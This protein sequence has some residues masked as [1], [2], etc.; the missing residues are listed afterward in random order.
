MPALDVSLI[1][2]YFNPRPRKE[3]DKM[4][5]TEINELINFNP[6]PRKEGDRRRHKKINKT[7]NFN[8]RPRKEGD[9]LYST[10]LPSLVVFQ[11]TPS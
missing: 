10:C 5:I 4:D 11:S 3:G 6:R 2:F 7:G 8:P 9:L 1:S